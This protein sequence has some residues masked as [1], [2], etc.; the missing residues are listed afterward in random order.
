MQLTAKFHSRQASNL[1]KK[2]TGGDDADGNVTSSSPKP[3]SLS[4]TPNP[5]SSAS[6]G[7]ARRRSSSLLETSWPGTRSHSG[8]LFVY[9]KVSLLRVW[10]WMGA[11]PS[12]PVGLPSIDQL[13]LHSQSKRKTPSYGEKWCVLSNANLRYFNARDSMADPKEMILLKD[14]LSINKRQT[15]REGRRIQ[16]N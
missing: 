4:A 14:V 15:A 9:S 7:A 6:T 10:M 1:S 2:H 12:I 13:S 16:F 11:V 3:Q 8:P 5:P